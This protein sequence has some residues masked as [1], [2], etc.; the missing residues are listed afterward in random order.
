MRK[1]NYGIGLKN[2]MLIYRS[3]QK[4]NFVVSGLRLTDHFLHMVQPYSKVLFD[5][6]GPPCIVSNFS[7]ANDQKSANNSC[8]VHRLS[9]IRISLYLTYWSARLCVKVLL[10]ILRGSPTMVMGALVSLF[11]YIKTKQI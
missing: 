6:L 3:V 1:A 11:F 4:G 9:C 7:I 10:S 8:Y 5:R 2:S